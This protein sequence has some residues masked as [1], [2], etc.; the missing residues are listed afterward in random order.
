MKCIQYLNMNILKMKNLTNFI[1][2]KNIIL[3]IF[4]I[5][6]KLKSNIYCFVWHI[7]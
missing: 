3:F 1:I 2:S 5:I 4:N 6:K 7:Q